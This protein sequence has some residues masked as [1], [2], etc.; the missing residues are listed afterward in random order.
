MMGALMT[1]TETE[2]RASRVGAIAA[3]AATALFFSFVFV[4]LLK[5][6]TDPDVP[7]H[8]ATGRYIVEHGDVPRE[9][10]PFSFAADEV[11][12]LGRFSL[13]QYWL[14]QAGLHRLHG[15]FGPMGLVVAQTLAL[16]LAAL[17]LWLLLRRQ[18]RLF[19]YAAVGTV[20]LGVLRAYI[21]ARPQVLTFLFTAVLILLVERFRETGRT[22]FLIPLPALFLLWANVHGGFI[23][24][25]VVLA[26]YAAAGIAGKAAPRGWAA[27]EFEE[28]GALRR[29]L[30]FAGASILVS[31]LNPNGFGPFRAALMAH[32]PV[33]SYITE[34][35][36]PLEAQ[37]TLV[38]EADDYVYWAMLPLAGAMAVVFA[39]KRRT[40]PLLLVVLS[41]AMSL[42]ALRYIPLFAITATA[43]AGRLP[44][45]VEP[46]LRQKAR[47]LAD[48]LTAAG[49]FAAVLAA[50][51]FSNERLY[52]MRDS[53]YYPVK[54][55][56][57]M[58]EQGIRGNIFATYNKSGY[59]LFGTYPDSRIYIDSRN[60]TMR[61]VVTALRIVG[62]HD[63]FDEWVH[64]LSSLLPEGMGT[65]RVEAEGPGLRRPVG[66]HIP[67]DRQWD[68]LLDEIGAE[69]I[70]CETM[71]L[72]T[73]L[74]Y[75]LALKLV[76]ADDWHLVYVDGNVMILLRDM[77]KCRDVIAEHEKPKEMIYDE[78]VIEGIRQS[79]I[80]SIRKSAPYYASIGLALAL[81]GELT[82]NTERTIRKALEM[83]PGNF[84]AVYA[85]LLLSLKRSGLPE[86]PP[87]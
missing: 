31:A 39:V 82:E 60:M 37:A 69:I 22:R 25:V 66:L 62:I 74:I 19:A 3:A 45:R 71:N 77:E 53:V 50:P 28:P 42:T 10:D 79:G 47:T 54:A 7:W 84:V 85:D 26:V 41:A 6:V 87:P 48:M 64:T 36:S 49:L 52:K 46:P 20:T 70:V 35:H 11:G 40:A 2:H 51:G 30:L 81:K 5:P 68:D 29:F 38:T 73:K 44:W 1:G 75:P 21:S 8:L 23:Y 33:L 56:R 43:M 32:N 14:A 15:A 63:T 57:F 27:D 18:G 55:V 78:I 65:I 83:E 34:Y 58:N 4:S 12:F 13:S 72:Y 17:V 67:E 80:T 86:A 61:R 76:T 24:G 9:E 59:V 16:T